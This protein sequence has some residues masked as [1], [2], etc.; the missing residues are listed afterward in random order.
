MTRMDIFRI[1][2]RIFDHKIENWTNL[3]DLITM[4]D[5]QIQQL[6]YDI[7]RTDNFLLNSREASIPVFASVAWDEKY[8]YASYGF[9]FAYKYMYMGAD[10]Y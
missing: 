5:N 3:S 4:I 8:H 9:D 10:E 7:P 1:G 6:R 2:Q